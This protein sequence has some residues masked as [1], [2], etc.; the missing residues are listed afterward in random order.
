MWEWSNEAWCLCGLTAGAQGRYR[1]SDLTRR[2]E[3]KTPSRQTTLS[4]AEARNTSWWSNFA[5]MHGDLQHMATNDAHFAMQCEYNGFHISPF[6]GFIIRMWRCKGIDAVHAAL[7]WLARTLG[8][9]PSSFPLSFALDYM[10]A[11]LGASWST[12]QPVNTVFSL[13]I[14]SLWVLEAVFG[15]LLGS[16]SSL[17]KLW[18]SFPWWKDFLRPFPSGPSWAKRFPVWSL[19]NVHR[20][21][22]LCL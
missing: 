10:E 17:T 4:A 1:S 8:V 3:Q 6:N 9:R 21:S 19:C 20:H 5:I 11:E 12:V 22:P 13:M 2:T 16:V 7:C 14:L 18:F 15:R